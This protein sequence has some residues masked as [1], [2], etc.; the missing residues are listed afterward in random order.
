MSTYWQKRSVDQ[1]YEAMKDAENV[2]DNIS[3]AYMKASLWLDQGASD[4]FER[5]KTK[6]KLTDEDWRNREKWDVYEDAVNEMIQK[7]S[8]KIAPWYIVESND[9]LYARIKVMKTVIE[10]IE[11]ALSNEK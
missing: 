7:T 5:F 11:K 8:T 2:A 9:K 6:W 3:I 10:T 1:L 4:I